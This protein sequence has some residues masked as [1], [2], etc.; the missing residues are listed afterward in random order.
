MTRSIGLLPRKTLWILLILA[1]V[2]GALVVPIAAW[3]A[4]PATPLGAA[5]AP[6]DSSATASRAEFAMLAVTGLGLPTSS[7]TTPTFRDVPRG[8]LYYQ[9]I[10]GA[11]ASGLVQG[12]GGG[13]YGPDL[14]IARQQVA[15]ILA[16]YLSAMELRARGYITGERGTYATLAGWF[17]AEGAE[18]LARFGDSLSI[19]SV[20]RTGVAYLAMHDI[21]LGSNGW[22]NPLS[23]VTVGQSVSFIARTAEVAASFTTPPPPPPA[24]APVV[25][26]ISPSTG[27]YLGGTSVV[28]SGTGFSSGAT[29][30]FGTVAATSL[31]VISSTSIVAASPAGTPGSTVQVSVTTVAGTSANT[32]ADDFTYYSYGAPSIT[33]LSSN[34]GWQ[35]DAVNIY[36]T[37]FTGEGLQVWFGGQQVAASSIAF[38]D[39][40]RLTVVVPWGYAGQT[41]RVKVVTAYGVSADTAADDFTFYYISAPTITGLDPNYG[42]EDDVI[43]I[44]GT[45]FV[46]GDTAVYFGA[47]QVDAHDITYYGSTHLVVVV[48]GG[49]NGQTVRVKVVTGYGT[50]P[51]TAADDFT[52]QLVDDPII[53][54][55]NPDYGWHGDVVTISGHNFTTDGLE[56]WFGGVQVVGSDITYYSPTKL[57]AVV[58]GGYFDGQTVRVTVVTK[59]G[60]SGNTAA[61][62]FTYVAPDFHVTGID[63]AQYSV[64]GAGVWQSGPSAVF[65]NGTYLDFRVR[66]VDQYG[67]PIV[68]TDVSASS[69]WAYWYKIES[70]FHGVP[71]SGGPEGQGP[72]STVTDANGYLYWTSLGG[73][74]DSMYM[75]LLGLNLNFGFGPHMGVGDGGGARFD[76]TWTE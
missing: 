70:R 57:K 19:S 42:W 41:V 38:V 24:A 28:I 10:E 63:S 22:F 25:T 43:S 71:I 15:T 67:D 7:P 34:H 11:Y 20:H 76:I 52:Y 65:V 30:R 21:A 68:L 73:Y 55:L 53:T 46:H 39:S 61:D 45:S 2:A 27:P 3:A 32:S 60:V 12:L 33:S 47:V 9:Y 69:P 36:G 62:D 31:S 4:E 1:L 6:L 40:T 23:L 74:S 29:V 16:R 37:N 44:Y 35:G 48:P 66:V 50:S 64:A 49:Y 54:G 17:E 18:Q 14:S 26:S 51:N 8:S 59:Y 72:A 56:V 5:A 75:F 58:P 13:L